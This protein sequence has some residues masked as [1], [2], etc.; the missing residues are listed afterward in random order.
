MREPSKGGTGNKLN[1][2]S[3]IFI[4]TMVDKTILIKIYIICVCSE[5]SYDAGIANEYT[6]IL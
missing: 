5:S 1:A 4:E 6:N 3:I 2:A